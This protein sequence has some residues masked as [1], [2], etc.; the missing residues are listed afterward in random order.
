M[1][2]HIAWGIFTL[3]FSMMV[4]VTFIAY[5]RKS[6]NTGL[7]MAKIQKMRAEVAVK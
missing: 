2:K 7:D 3:F 4:F 5:A 6:G 1:F